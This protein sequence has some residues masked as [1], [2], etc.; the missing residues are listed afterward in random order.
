MSQIISKKPLNVASKGTILGI[1]YICG[2]ITTMYIQ[3][4]LNYSNYQYFLL[5]HLYVRTIWLLRKVSLL[6]IMVLIL[7]WKMVFVVTFDWSSFKRFTYI[8]TSPKRMNLLFY[9]N[10]C[11]TL[12]VYLIVTMSTPNYCSHVL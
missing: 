2:I 9:K 7:I 6:F 1:F 12:V 11:T 3:Y 8:F 4:W 10:T 5:F